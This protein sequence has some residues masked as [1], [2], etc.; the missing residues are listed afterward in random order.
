MASST[1]NVV[2]YTALLT[3]V[4]YGIT[5]RRTLQKTHDEELKHHAIHERE[6]LIAQAKEAWKKQQEGSKD[7][8]ITDPED[9]GFD[10]EK[11]IAKWESE[12]S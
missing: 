7:G 4:F 2:R 8:V 1:V 12:S 10:L 9:P 11:L 5:H 6:H 3:G